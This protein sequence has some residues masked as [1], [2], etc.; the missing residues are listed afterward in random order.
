MSIPADSQDNDNACKCLE[1]M[2]KTEV[3]GNDSS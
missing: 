2:L 3:I 1:F